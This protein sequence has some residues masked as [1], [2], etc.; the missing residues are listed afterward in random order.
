LGI[1]LT[2]GKIKLLLIPLAKDVNKYISIHQW[3]LRLMYIIRSAKAM[4]KWPKNNK[5]GGLDCCPY[6]YL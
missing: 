2:Y 4:W 5:T 1:I 3:H 6:P